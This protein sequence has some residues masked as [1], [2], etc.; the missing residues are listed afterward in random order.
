MTF[1]FNEADESKTI[2]TFTNNG[3]E[4]EVTYIDGRT[5]KYKSSNPEEEIHRLNNEILASLALRKTQSKEP[6][7]RMARMRLGTIL[8]LLSTGA[9][10]SDENALVTSA[11]AIGTAFFGY[12][13][14]KEIQKN[15]ELKKY[16]LILDLYNRFDEFGNKENLTLANADD[17]SYKEVKSIY[18]KFNGNR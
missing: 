8:L 9:S 5:E 7:W 12:A 2:K 11:F 17:F 10:L 13:A 6:A 1:V 16:D 15:R 14:V 18:S 3:E 4:F